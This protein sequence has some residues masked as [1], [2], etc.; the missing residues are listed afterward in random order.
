MCN[1]LYIDSYITTKEREKK[2]LKLGGPKKKN[3]SS[4]SLQG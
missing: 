2:K 1:Y 3:Y 4:H